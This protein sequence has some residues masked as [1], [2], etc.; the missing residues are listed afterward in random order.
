MKYETNKYPDILKEFITILM[1]QGCN[2]SYLIIICEMTQ[3]GILSA[4]VFQKGWL[5]KFIIYKL[6]KYLKS[7][8]KYTKCSINKIKL[9]P[10]NQMVGIK[11]K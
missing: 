8:L 2:F 5:N 3:D 10:N 1:K 4:R 9:N 7:R 6:D 11:Y